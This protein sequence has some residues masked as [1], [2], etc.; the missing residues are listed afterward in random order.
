MRLEVQ[1]FDGKIDF[2]VWI[3]KIKALLSHH[4]VL[5]SLQEKEEKW[6]EE[7][8]KRKEEIDE[9]VYNILVLIYHTKC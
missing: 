6:S 8:K 7:K 2:G 4:K 1:N 5:I 9:E 3:M